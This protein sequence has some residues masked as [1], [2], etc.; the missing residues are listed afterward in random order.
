LAVGDDSGVKVRVGKAVLVGVKVFVAWNVCVGIGVDDAV[1]VAVFGCRISA[2]GAA[3]AFS[4]KM[5]RQ[6]K[7]NKRIFITPTPWERLCQ[8]YQ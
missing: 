3:Q 1:I 2:F 4:S 5:L 8:L 7:F 6:D